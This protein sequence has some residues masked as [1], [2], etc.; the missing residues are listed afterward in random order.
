MKGDDW[1]ACL[2]MTQNWWESAGRGI[3]IF[4][5]KMERKRG[6]KTF[7]HTNDIRLLT[8]KLGSTNTIKYKWG[9]KSQTEKA[10]IQS[11]RLKIL[12]PFVEKGV[13]FLS[14]PDDDKSSCILSGQSEF[15]LRAKSSTSLC[16]KVP[17]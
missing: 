11:C 7:K 16:Q 9:K 13:A 4:P 1:G 14:W 2:Q 17:C 3:C 6:K 8:V 5:Y 15:N 12:F 10:S